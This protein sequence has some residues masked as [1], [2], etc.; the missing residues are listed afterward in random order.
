MSTSQLHMVFG[1]SLMLLGGLSGA[2]IGLRFHQAQWAG[3][4]GSFRRRLLR[5]GHIAFF[6]LGILN[7]LFALATI[8]APLRHPYQPLASA[9]FVV[10]GVCMPL[11]CFLTAWREPFR[12]MFAIPV[13]G[14]LLGAG[15]LL[16][17]WVAA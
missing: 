2:V 5:L 17:G 7:V 11:C 13:L 9:G 10:A 12:H 3:G 4:Y 8:Q 14:V 16:L 6:G 15:A 1:W